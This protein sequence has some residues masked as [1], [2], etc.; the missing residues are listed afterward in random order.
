MAANG[1][2]RD[3]SPPS[4][5]RLQKGKMPKSLITQDYGQQTF[6]EDVT[7]VDYRSSRDSHDLSLGAGTRD[8]VVD[9]MLLSL[10]QILPGGGMFGGAQEVLYS[11]YDH[12]DVF[13][14]NGHQGNQATSHPSRHR[15]HTYTSSFSSDYDP[16]YE[17]RFSRN[18]SRERR[19]N[20]S[21]NIPTNIRKTELTRGA[22]LGSVR[23]SNDTIRKGYDNK[24]TTH[25]RG[26]TKKGS[27]SSGS[28]SVDYGHSVAARTSRLGNRSQSFDHTF[29]HRMISSS[30]VKLTQSSILDRGRP[31]PL[32]Y[33]SYD[34]APT[35]TVPAGPRRYQ[36]SPASSPMYPPQPSYPPPKAPGSS[37]RDSIKSPTNKGPWKSKSDTVDQSMRSQANDF[38]NAANFRDLPPLPGFIDPPAPS[39][40]VATR[41][42]SMVAP[43]PA[44]P[45]KDR[46]GFFRRLFGSSRHDG[47]FHTTAPTYSDMPVPPQ[48]LPQTSHSYAGS[49]PKTQTGQNHIAA[50]MKSSPG[51][52]FQ[53]S[54]SDQKEKQRPATT[55]TLH[56]KQSF[57]RRRKK[58]FVEESSPPPVPDLP[59]PLRISDVL[60]Q[61]SASTSSLRK[62][63][64]PFFADHGSPT[65]VTP[66]EAYFD[67]REHQLTMEEAIKEGHSWDPLQG[68]S[69]GYIPHHDAKVR[70]V[71]PVSRE[72][73]K[74]GPTSNV[75]PV[76]ISHAGTTD[77]PKFKLKVKRGRVNPVMHDDTFLADSSGNEDK[78]GG[79]SPAARSPTLPKP[80][81]ERRP[82]TSPTSPPYTMH[83]AENTPLPRKANI[84]EKRSELLS[85]TTRE[86]PKT[87]SSTDFE[88]DG[89]VITTPSKNVSS[90]RGAAGKQHRV[91]LE[92]TS[93]EENLAKPDLLALPLEGARTSDKAVVAGDEPSPTSAS[94]VFQSATSLPVVQVEGDEVSETADGTAEDENEP[95]PEDRERAQKI[96]DGDEEFI[97]K[98]R[99]TAWLG[100][101]T[102][103]S[104]RTRK[105]YLELYDFN[106]LNI[107][108][109]LRELCSKLVLKAET[110][111]L[112]RVVTDFSRRWC[113]CNP[114]HG[115][116]DEDVVHTICFSLLL[117]NTDL[118]VASQDT[119]MT[120]QTYVKNTTPTLVST[121]RTAMR[122]AALE[123]AH[124]TARDI[125]NQ[126]R[127]SIA[128]TGPSSSGP[129]SPTLP[130]NV[131]E[132]KPSLEKKRSRNRLSIRPLTHRNDSDGANPDS[133]A[134][135]GCN[136]LVN[137]PHEGSLRSW[138][139]QIEIV[140]KE[141]YNSI[142]NQP[143]PL[144]GVTEK[145]LLEQRSNNNLSVM[146]GTFLRRSPSVLSKAPSDSISFQ[147]R[148]SELRSASS[149]WQ[150]NRSRPRFY[151][152]STMGSSRT[153]LDEA[154]VWSPTGS[155]SWSKYSFGKTQPSSMSVDSFGSQF[156][157]G[158]YQQ[159]IGFANALSHAITRDEANAAAPKDE[160][161]MRVAPLLDDESLELAGAPWAKEGILKHKHHIAAGNRKAKDRNWNERF[162]VIEK[163]WMRLFSFNANSKS[164]RLKSKLRPAGGVVG[165]GNWTENAESLNQFLLRHAHASALPPP[166]CSKSRP[167][168]F[169]LTF[170]DGAIHLFQVG[171]PE[172]VKEF[173]STANYWAAR[174]SKEPL[175][176][177]VS[178]IEYGWSENVINM[179]LIRPESE[180]RSGRAH[181]NS[182]ILQGRPSLQNSIR[183]SVDQATGGSTV[184]ARLPGDKVNIT[185]WDPPQPSVM[186]STLM[187]VD[188]LKTLTDHVVNLKDELTKHNE[189]LAP[190]QIAFSPR[191][192]N[193]TKAM[194]NWQKKSH[195]LL[196]EIVRFS[197]YVDALNLAQTTKEKIYATRPTTAD[198]NTDADAN[199]SKEEHDDFVSV[200]PAT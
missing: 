149:R 99:V 47:P 49:R 1:H 91:W 29:E 16:H 181:S 60:P 162:A 118:H 111:Q 168:V 36:E 182:L 9:N 117:L 166:G 5:P 122:F 43:S 24:G 81:Q 105:A 40:T 151:P 63:M 62:V 98:D 150:K 177:G 8:S 92:A 120:R 95:T 143:L 94:D 198:G 170:P 142:K 15:G 129:S 153:S 131:D 93:S 100:E 42:P 145:R 25:S 82:S 171:T 175:V 148:S 163:G 59:P 144:H 161:F 55:P 64:D 33:N 84:G 70:T 20:S 140:L 155:S 39:P 57:F 179:A 102:V 34:A 124:E 79:P 126:G 71:R 195:H 154:S 2:P 54:G 172:I 103:T 135:D 200:G 53:Q 66:R 23:V 189:L 152:S 19:S 3:E 193:S 178:N 183:N 90:E 80:A 67:S 187:E 160:D 52:P 18:Q 7:P 137:A 184:R 110:Q 87:S 17:D 88:D 27:K 45:P 65:D 190:M 194:T 4:T 85:P 6:F 165:G 46:H 199:A 13:T 197:T 44:N 112:D 41:K 107:L 86:V 133:A 14:A 78:S 48:I 173:V 10:D 116:K 167:H 139:F 26:G 30:P 11:A 134:L 121:V 50:Q 104:S 158:D 76:M 188:Q 130:Q 89:W 186:A 21:S 58:S 180:T 123:S 119:K 156:T 138:E 31:S 113:A 196:R 128:R 114:N 73:Q 74:S 35:P 69:P 109:S 146:T 12:E 22:S 141:H 191:H 176:G 136:I 147:G 32:T 115:F 159:S 77:S 72:M 38:F 185:R 157:T 192:P 56:K 101:T 75:E 61:Q 174:L 28:S 125:G 83:N 96:Y 106:G 164:L 37:R 132:G 127:S 169:A 68:F 108:S 51:G 97:T